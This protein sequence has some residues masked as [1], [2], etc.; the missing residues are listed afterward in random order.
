MLGQDRHQPDDQR[1]LAV[2]AAIE[3]EFDLA[4]AGL[5]DL[6][7]LLV[8]GAVIGAAVIAQQPERED[9]VVD[10]NRRPIREFRLRPQGEFDGTA[11]VGRFDALGDQ[12]IKREGLVIGARQQALVEIIAQAL[13]G[14]A[15]D[16]QGIEAVERALHAEDHAPAFASVGIDVGEVGEAIWLRRRAMHREPLLRLCHSAAGQEQDEAQNQG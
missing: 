12:T 7:D 13:G 8:I 4:L 10:G 6:G 11:V 16:D 3:G 2:A 1:H 14:V 9:D 5:L 15:L